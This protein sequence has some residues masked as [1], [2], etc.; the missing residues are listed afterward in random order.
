MSQRRAAA[1]ASEPVL[2]RA[3]GRKELCAVESSARIHLLSLS[4]ATLRRSPTPLQII[5]LS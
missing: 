1:C 3:G 2:V 5:P 4:P